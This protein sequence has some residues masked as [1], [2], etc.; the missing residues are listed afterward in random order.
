[1][2]ITDAHRQAAKAEAEREK[3]TSKMSDAAIEKLRAAKER[4]ARNRVA[5]AR[6]V[7]EFNSRDH[8]VESVMDWLYLL[9]R[10][11]TTDIRKRAI[12]CLHFLAKGFNVYTIHDF[13]F[14]GE[15][16][17]E[18]EQ[19]SL[20]QILDKYPAA[21]DVIHPALPEAAPGR[22]CAMG[23][24]CLRAYRRKAAVVTGT[25]KYCSPICRAAAASLSMRP[26]RDELTPEMPEVAILTCINTGVEGGT[27]SNQPDI[28]ATPLT[29]FFPNVQKQPD[30]LS[31]QTITR[32]LKTE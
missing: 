6:L 18:E 10:D 31:N 24:K 7:A 16:L 28:G 30:L 13:A 11:Q 26:K 4:D 8:S 5:D 32:R 17:P 22:L 29:R 25:G 2:K 12:K 15:L 1:M 9:R 23:S 3:A 21:V 27:P 20:V 14:F 19:M